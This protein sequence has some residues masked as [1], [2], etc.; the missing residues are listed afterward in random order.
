MAQFIVTKQ[1]QVSGKYTIHNR[2]TGCAHLP[3]QG[4]Q[5]SLGYYPSCQE[6]LEDALSRWPD[7]QID[8]CYYCA[9]SCHSG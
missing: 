2:T 9:N 1:K 8:G 5:V 4:Q 3:S 7:K 6:A